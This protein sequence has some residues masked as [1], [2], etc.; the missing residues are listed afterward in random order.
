MLGRARIAACLLA[1]ALPSLARSERPTPP[2]D[3]PTLVR[4]TVDNEISKAPAASHFMFRGTNTTP[5][6]STTK[7]YVES[8][9]GTAG[10]AIAYNGK[11]LT[12]EQR[13]SEEARVS[14]FVTNPD[15]LKKKRKQE[16]EDED[17]SMRIIRAIPDAFL[18]EYAG[19]QPGTIDMGKPGDP[20]VKLKF[21]PNPQYDP[22]SKVEQILTGMQGIMLIDAAH[23][24]LALIDG[25]L[26][27]DVGFGWGILGRLDRGGRFV[28]Q[29]RQLDAQ[30]WEIS[31]MD[32]SL[33]GKILL[34]KHFSF[35]ET[36]VFSDYKP[37][38]MDLTF[39][40]ALEMIKKE[41]ATLAENPTT[42][43][44]ALK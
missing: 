23:D 10:M 31:R 21:R 35:I 29:Q 27:K 18:F 13:Q 36:Q 37:V 40:Q 43:K 44:L 5:K 42:S 12:P 16:Q 25:T 39:A 20:L 19:E 7:L 24:R 17:R 1:L 8:R 28:V 38:P 32:L 2:P 3:I 9:E 11:P 26:F 33:T 34:I 15:E 14:R 41:Q 30:R 6:G 22:P 4:R